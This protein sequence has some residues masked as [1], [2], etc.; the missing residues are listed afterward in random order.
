MMEQQARELISTWSLK[1]KIGQLFI[2][3]FPGKSAETARQMIEEYNLGGCYLS[4]DNAETFSEAQKLNKELTNILDANQRLPLLLGVDQ[5]G[6]W[7]VLVGES[8]TGPGNLALGVSDTAENTENM[9][10]VMADEMRFAGFN[11]ILGP[12]CDVNFNPQSPII[13]TRSFGDQP[14]KVSLHSAAAVRGLHQGE[15]IACAKH[16][17]GHGDTHADTHREIPQVDKSYAQLKANDLMPFQAAINAGVDL[18]MTSHI[19]YPQLDSVHPATL[20][21]TILQQVLRQDMGF[22]GIIISDSMNMG[23]I[24]NHYQPVDAAIKAMKA[25]I[26]MLMLSEEHYDHSDA[27]IDKQ[28]AMIHGLIDAVQSGEL[29]EYVIDQA[30]LKVV[31]FKLE[32]L[33]PISLYQHI[34][35]QNN[36]QVALKSAECGV[37][38]V[39][40]D[41][42]LQN[43]RLYVMNATPPESYH[44]LINPRGIG[45]NQSQPAYDVFINAL[46]NTSLNWQAVTLDTLPSDIKDH[47]LV[48]VT[49][50]HPLPGED[51][52]QTQAQKLVQ[53]LSQDFE[54]L[55]VVGLRSPYDLLHY[56]NI[57]HYLCAHSSR[58]ESAIAAAKLLARQVAGAQSRAVSL[59]G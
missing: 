23:A 2:L 5:E 3:A 40:G 21:S 24:M 43:Q 55:V 45:P 29:P 4:Q 33:L 49:E 52:D 12:C 58:P 53:Q 39:R 8:T 6:A 35:I 41:I 56:P 31:V 19:L 22:E 10:Q 34:D 48:V 59:V 28:L 11:C 18:I 50:N 44:N 15:I 54:Q 51:F 47:Y 37:S 9:Y 36:Q 20:S 14:D 1:E 46:S 13:D 38:W 27:Y 16:F 26:T 42:D 57:H 25:G 32:K 17:P 30:L 7:G